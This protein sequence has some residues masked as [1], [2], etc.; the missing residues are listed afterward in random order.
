V[1]RDLSGIV[2]DE[3]ASEELQSRNRSR[4]RQEMLNAQAEAVLFEIQVLQMW[5]QAF[6]EWSRPIKLQNVERLGEG[7]ANRSQRW[8][9]CRWQ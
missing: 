8:C 1:N 6:Q 3:D 7:E 2:G 5:K 4:Q 9:G